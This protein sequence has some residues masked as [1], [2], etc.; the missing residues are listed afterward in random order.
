MK[1]VLFDLDGTLIDSD[2]DIAAAVNQTLEEL[3]RPK[4]SLAEIR[5]MIG[6]GARDLLARALD[7]SDD[8]AIEAARARFVRHYTAAP[9][10]HTKIYPG[11]IELLEA[12]HR[13]GLALGVATNKPIA[14]A[15][16]IVKA[17][18]LD[19]AGIRGVAAADEVERRKPDPAVLALALERTCPGTPPAEVVYVGDM[20]LDVETARAF[21]AAA[22]G[23]GWGFSRA[24][25]I[26]AGP[27]VFIERPEELL[28]WMKTR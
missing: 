10:A 2:E 17:L 24:T 8:A 23:V 11:V 28:A 27:D 21:G 6:R 18:G 25:V 3:G 19:R 1:A 26:A 9:V 12:L 16:P 14:L 15:A 7:S 4:R 13:Q 22:V 20:G 5:T